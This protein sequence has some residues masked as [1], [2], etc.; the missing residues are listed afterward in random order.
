MLR[1]RTSGLAAVTECWKKGVTPYNELPYIEDVKQAPGFGDAEHRGPE[2]YS[3]T[4][5]ERDISKSHPSSE[6]TS[7]ISS[8][9]HHSSTTMSA[10]S[11]ESNIEERAGRVYR[12]CTPCAHDMLKKHTNLGIKWICGGYQ[13]ARR[14]FKSECMMRYRNCQDGTS[15]VCEVS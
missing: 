4:S 5:G 6:S 14:T 13:R 3:M 8:G 2:W 12:T 1:Y 11:K 9:S 7:S 15:G 10:S